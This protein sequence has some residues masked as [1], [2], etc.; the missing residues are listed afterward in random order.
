MR[1]SSTSIPLSA[2][3]EK[4]VMT[5]WVP[6]CA[7]PVYIILSLT[8]KK[9]IVCN[10]AVRICGLVCNSFIW[11]PRNWYENCLSSRSSPDVELTCYLLLQHIYIYVFI[12]FHLGMS[13][14]F[15]FIMHFLPQTLIPA[16]L[17]LMFV[18]GYLQG[19]FLY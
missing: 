14:K 2:A 3:I 17:V 11:K 16:T 1:P 12:S 8:D 5:C 4:D 9:L 18:Q 6:D 7:I 15:I 10:K 13:L 19:N